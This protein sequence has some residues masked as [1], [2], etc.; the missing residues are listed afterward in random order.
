MNTTPYVTITL[1][2]AGG[3]SVTLGAV[4]STT[5]P[6][7]LIEGAQGLGMAPTS[8]STAARLV[9]HGSIHRGTRMDE[10]EI[11]LPFLLDPGTALDYNSWL[12]R[13]TRLVSPLDERE[14]T[15][16]VTPIGRSSWREIPVKYSGGL[17]GLGEKYRGEYGTI[18][19][20][21]KAFDALWRGAPQTI[22]QQVNPGR[23]PFLS[24]TVNFFP[25]ELADAVIA[26]EITVNV[27]GDA[28]TW[29]TWT[30]SPPGS[31][32]TIVKLAT[33]ETFQLLGLIDETITL[34]MR[35]GRLTSATYPNGELWDDVPPDKGAM[36][37]LDP[38]NNALQFAVVGASESSFL[39]MVYQPRYL[40]GH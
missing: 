10:R 38:G 3:D 9:G 30:V 17:D 27:T 5:S 28:P 16:R 40:R 25:V 29:P 22:K 6:L 37:Q 19:L 34:D 23:K 26:G 1:H 20:R 8:H 7:V 12:D 11:F 31:D 21:F 18:G 2:R 32:L 13:L 14:L 4:H 39:H 36:F 33:G 35:R 15:L 24:T